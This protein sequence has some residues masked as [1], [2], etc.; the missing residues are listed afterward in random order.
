[1]KKNWLTILPV[2]TL[3][4]CLGGGGGSS[5]GTTPTTQVP[6]EG[7]ISAYYQAAHYYTLSGQVG[8]N[9]FSFQI[10]QTPGAASTFN[11]Q[12][13]SLTVADS[14]ITSENNV[15]IGTANGEDYFSTS[16]FEHLGF[17]VLARTEF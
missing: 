8:N 17:V 13:A 6:V 15:V 9:T 16:P 14:G 10:S 12:A 3:S 11:G 2:L 1:M 7:A 5:G 4:A